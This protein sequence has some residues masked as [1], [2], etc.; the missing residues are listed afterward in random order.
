MSRKMKITGTEGGFPESLQNCLGEM[1]VLFLL[2]QKPT[3]TYEIMQEINRISNGAFSNKSLYPYIF[4]IGNPIIS[5]AA[6]TTP[7]TQELFLEKT[8]LE[9]RI[10]VEHELEIL[11]SNV[12]SNYCMPD[13]WSC[14]NRI[15]TRSG[16]KYRHNKCKI[17]K[18]NEYF[19]ANVTITCSG[20]GEIS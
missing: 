7:N 6:Q 2:K 10:T 20:S 8:V 9:H 16:N 11:S 4:T 17:S 12:R 18:Y 13:G 15:A 3:N 14:K 1:L 5:H 19:N